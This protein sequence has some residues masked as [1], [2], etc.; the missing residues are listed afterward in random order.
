VLVAISEFVSARNGMYRLF[1][2]FLFILGEKGAVFSL[3]FL[4]LLA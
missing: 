3:K 1:W 2:L 4:F